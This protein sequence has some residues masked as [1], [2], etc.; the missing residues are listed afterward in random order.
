MVPQCGVISMLDMKK[1]QMQGY[2]WTVELNFSFLFASR[3]I[4]YV[5]WWKIGRSQ[6]KAEM[7][8]HDQF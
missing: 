5:C 8:L 6:A 2:H 4:C 7:M 1:S 3:P